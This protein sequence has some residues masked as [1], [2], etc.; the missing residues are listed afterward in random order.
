LLVSHDCQSL[1]ETWHRLKENINM[2]F[3]E[4]GWEGMNWIYLGQ[5]RE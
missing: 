3:K 1:H 5:D 2:K 4:V